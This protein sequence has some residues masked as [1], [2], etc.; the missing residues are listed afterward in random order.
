MRHSISSTASVGSAQSEASN[1][2]APSLSGSRSKRWPSVSDLDQDDL[3][4]DELKPTRSKRAK[5]N[6]YAPAGAGAAGAAH[7]TAGAR[8]DGG[9]GGDKEARRIARMLRNRNAAQASR[10]RKKEHAS[11]LEQRVAELEAMLS[12]APTPAPAQSQSA[13]SSRRRAHR[14][15][16]VISSSTVSV[17]P[18]QQQVVLAAP[19][20]ELLVDLEDENEQ[21]RNQLHSEQL[22]SARLRGRLESLED[23]F[24]RLE[25]FMSMPLG[26]ELAQGSHSDDLDEL[27]AGQRLKPSTAGLSPPTFEPTTSASGRHRITDDDG[28][29]SPRSTRGL[30][31]ITIADVWGDWANGLPGAAPASPEDE[32]VNVKEEDDCSMEFLDLSYLHDAPVAL[33]C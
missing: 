24:A 27:T 13:H 8:A 9:G 19:A 29:L 2:P 30:D 16:S 14:S 18:S 5:G 12:G 20:P 11:F 33:V 4:D 32:A 17:P 6:Q 31:A 21:L 15:A 26:A 23:K 28:Q 22:E 25:H 7:S 10:D 3:D 1:S